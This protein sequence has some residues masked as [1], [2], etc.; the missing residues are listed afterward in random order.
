MQPSLKLTTSK[1]LIKSTVGVD[2]NGNPGKMRGLPLLPVSLSASGASSQRSLRLSFG[3]VHSIFDD[4]RAV[5]F[6]RLMTS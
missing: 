5:A 3:V 6:A 1:Q 4:R 2:D